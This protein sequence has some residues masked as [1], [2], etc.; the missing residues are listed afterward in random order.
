ML[1]TLICRL[2]LVGSRSELI[3]L[4]SANLSPLLLRADHL[5]LY[6]EYISWL[7]SVNK[8]IEA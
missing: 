2:S 1:K 5:Y 8:F 3:S 6:R 4:A 7:K